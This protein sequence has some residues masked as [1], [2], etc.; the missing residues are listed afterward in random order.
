[1]QDGMQACPGHVRVV[2]HP[3]VVPLTVLCFPSGVASVVVSFFLGMYYNVVNTWGFWYLFHSF[4]VSPLPTRACAGAGPTP[5]GGEEV[6]FDSIRES[7]GVGNSVGESA[8]YPP[9]NS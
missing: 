6:E 8:T 4:Q 7:H 9:Q 2:G 1:M 5:G 3:L